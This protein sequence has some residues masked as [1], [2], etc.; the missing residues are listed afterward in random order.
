MKFG[1]WNVFG[2]SCVITV[3]SWS[4][5]LRRVTCKRISWLTISCFVFLSLP[6]HHHHLLLLLLILFPCFAAKKH[7]VHRRVGLLLHV[8]F[9]FFEWLSEVIAPSQKVRKSESQKVRKSESQKARKSESKEQIWCYT[10]IPET[11]RVME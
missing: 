5:L 10:N 7:V 3:I 11:M 4:L 6:S 8:V 9:T 2:W 1:S